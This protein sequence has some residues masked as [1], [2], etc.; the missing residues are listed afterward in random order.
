MK[1]FKIALL[2][3]QI[4]KLRVSKVIVCIKYLKVVLTAQI[5]GTK[6]KKVPNY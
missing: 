4:E 5:Y 2:Y 1:V 3:A 6:N